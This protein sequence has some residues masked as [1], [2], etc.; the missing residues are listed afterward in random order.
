MSLIDDV[1]KLGVNVEDGLERFMNNAS[2]Y[3]RMLKKL[4][5]VLEM[6]R[7]MPCLE[8]GDYETAFSNAHTI[9]G[10]AGNLSVEPL[11]KGY[12]GITSLLREGKNDEA[13]LLLEKTLELERP[14]VECI[15]K[16]SG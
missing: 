11:F 3:E 6:S 1:A 14:I 10:V 8:S 13:K 16:Y 5:S 15:K 2:L 7:V 4:P 9:K 12:S